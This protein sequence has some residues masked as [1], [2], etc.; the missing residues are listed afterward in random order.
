MSSLVF[1]PRKAA[2]TIIMHHSEQVCYY[3]PDLQVQK[4]MT[5]CWRSFS[6]WGRENVALSFAY[7]GGQYLIYEFLQ[8]IG[9]QITR[10]ASPLIIDA[11]LTLIFMT[12]LGV[13][14]TFFWL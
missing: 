1:L 12:G 2:N 8:P 3:L 7:K 10:D 11:P 14:F 13:C 6:Q 9:T 4:L 5:L